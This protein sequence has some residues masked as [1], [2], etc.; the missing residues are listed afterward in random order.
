MEPL[1]QQ[2]RAGCRVVAFTGAGVSTLSGI[3]DYRGKNGVYRDCDADRI[4]SLADFRRDPGFYYR[5]TRDF[6]Y[7]LDEKQPSIVH[8]ELARLEERGLVA[9]VITQNI[10]MLHQRAGSRRTIE[11]HGSPRIHACPRCGLEFPFAWAKT[12]VQA[13]RIPSCVSCGTAVKP[14][15]TFFGEMLPPGAFEDAVALARDADIMLVLGS[16]LVVQP[17]ASI[18][19]QALNAGARLVIVNDGETPLDDRATDRYGDLATFFQT[20]AAALP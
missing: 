18:P 6:I 16:S 17:A 9:G 5:M 14:A 11:L 15:I 13:G 1:L 2:L 20:L 3:R 7:N 4:F 8:T 12:H 19:V 10:D